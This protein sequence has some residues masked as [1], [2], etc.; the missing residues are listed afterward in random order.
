MS[1][2]AELQEQLYA[3][4]ARQVCHGGCGRRFPVWDPAEMEGWEVDFQEGIYCPACLT[5][6]DD[7][8][9]ALDN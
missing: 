9:P 6:R 2:M 7:H 5:G 1:S 4:L 3:L 8:P